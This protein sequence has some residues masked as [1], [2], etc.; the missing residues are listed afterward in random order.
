M[1]VALKVFV[2]SNI[3][4]VTKFANTAAVTAIVSVTY[5]SG[6]SQWHLWYT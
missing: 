3:T 4:E 6:S 2:A 5:D 1:A